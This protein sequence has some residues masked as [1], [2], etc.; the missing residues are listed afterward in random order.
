MKEHVSSPTFRRPPLDGSMTLTQIYDWQAQNSPDHRMF[1]YTDSNGRVRNITWKEGVAAIYT[2]ARSIRSRFSKTAAGRHG[3]PVIAILS[4]TDTIT[5]FTTIMSILRANCI[6][7]PIS[8]RN[9][10]AAVANLLGKVEVGHVFIGEPAMEDLI[11]EAFQILGDEFPSHPAPSCSTMFLFEDLFL[12]YNEQALVLAPGELPNTLSNNDVIMYLHS[13]GNR[14]LAFPKPVHLTDRKLV[15]VGQ[16]PWCGEQDLMG[17][18]V[19]VHAAP[20]F[21]GL[22]II[23]LAWTACAGLVVAAFEPKFPATLPS[24]ENLFEGSRATSSD[25]ILCVPSFIEAWAR[26]PDYVQELSRCSGLVY[27]GGALNR[28]VGDYMTS[29]GVPI[30]NSYG[31]SEVGTLSMVLPAKIKDNYEWHYIRFSGLFKEHWRPAGDNLYE[32]VVV[33]SPQCTPSALN[34]EVDGIKAYATSDLFIP[35]PTKPN[36]WS[37]HGRVDDQIVHST[38]EKTNPGPLESLLSQDVHVGGAVMFG[39]GQFNAGVLIEPKLAFR[40]DPVEQTK[41]AVFRNLIWPVI[42]RMNVHAPQHSRLFKEMILVAS[43]AKPFVYTPKNTPRRQTVLR[44]YAE[45]ISQLYNAVSETT[46]SSIPAPEFWDTASVK[47]FVRAVVVGVLTHDVKDEDDLFQHG[48]DSLQATWIRNTLLRALRESA[49]LD[50]R[51]AT[52]N[53]VY[54]H[55]TID[56]L[57]TYVLSLA[58]GGVASDVLDD[59]AKKLEMAKLVDKFS[60]NFP[61]LSHYGEDRRKLPGKAVLL[62]GSTGSLGSYI[63][64]SL[65]EDPTVNHVFALIRSRSHTDL[66][67]RQQE[68]FET[69]GLDP[70][71]IKSGKLTLL[72]VDYSQDSL[73]LEAAVLTSI[74]DNVTHIID[75]AWRVDFNLEISS[76][77]T[78]LKGMR[79]LIDVAIRSGAQYTFS[80]TIAVCRSASDGREELVS[81]DAALG[82]GYS[83][84]KW[85]AEQVIARASKSAG[86]RGSIIRVGQLTGGRNGYW[87]AK[88]WVPSLVHAST[89]LKKIP[90]DNRIVSWIPLETAAKV[91]VELLD[92]PP[93]SGTPQVFHLVHPKPIPWTVL[94]Q[95]FSRALNAPLVPYSEWLQS[96]EK[97]AENPGGINLNAFVL[98]DFFRAIL[99]RVDETESEA[100]GVPIMSA[101]HIVQHSRSLSDSD[102]GLEQLGERDVAKWLEYWQK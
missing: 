2:G 80:S 82:S 73:G 44:L 34:T 11:K 92:S 16:I 102:K 21:H 77:Q 76:F 61:Q 14:S 47:S 57:S 27:G 99:A 1:V 41:L 36:H 51:I 25:I 89:A 35:H 70:N 62:T 5:Y 45:E 100:F 65:T 54:N 94:A 24:P 79:M 12:P 7:F 86:L 69:R 28:E 30:F 10:A 59:S 20:M 4:S 83:E 23:Q 43:P 64:S 101:Q 13:S 9:S 29:Q 3:V 88:E 97:L 58:T 85:V 55:P 63:L 74:H 93:S 26:R 52:S 98:L 84:S 6:A 60:D 37:Y 42:E 87:T 56:R 95:A 72:E 49:E 68:A 96:L 90:D 31:L 81:A 91:V 33:D 8:T 78:N 22:G 32:L 38:G 19:A 53:F 17:K 48:C 40:F 39:E 15:Q 50:T 18:V 71:M 46:Q 75:V 67:S 66:V